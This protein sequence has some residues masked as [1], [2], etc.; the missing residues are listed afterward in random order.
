MSRL[1]PIALD[2]AKAASSAHLVAHGWVGLEQAI[3]AYVSHVES[4][5]TCAEATPRLQER[6]TIVLDL[7][8]AF[9][10]NQAHAIRREIARA[11]VVAMKRGWT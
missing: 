2:H 8:Q 6:P 10:P 7:G 1:D 9:P 3:E 4:A 11:V 5:K